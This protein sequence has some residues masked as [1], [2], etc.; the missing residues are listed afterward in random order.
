MSQ[1][2]NHPLKKL[3][4]RS[5]GYRSQ[6]VAL[7]LLTLVVGAFGYLRIARAGGSAPQSDDDKRCRRCENKP[8]P[9][10]TPK[11]TP[12]PAP[13][14]DLAGQTVN[15]YY[16]REAT[17]IAAVLNA[18]ASQEDSELHGLVIST[19][20][21]NEI[22]LYGTKQQ[23]K[24]ARQV[25]ATLDLPRPGI[26]MEM[27]G[28][29]ISSEKP[30]ALSQVMPQVRAEINRTQRAVR[31]SFRKLQQLVREKVP[32]QDLE[33][34]FQWLLEKKLGYRTALQA[35]RELS[36]ADILLRL[37]AA[38]DPSWATR[39]VADGLNTWLRTSRYRDYLNE[40]PKTLVE[41]NQ[42]FERFFSTRG[43]EYQDNQWVDSGVRPQA[44][45]GRMAI[46]EFALHYGCLVHDPATFSPYSL[47]QAAEALNGRLQF[48]V[49]A[50]NLDIQDLFVAPTLLRIGE[51]VR[52]SPKVEYAQ[53][54]KTTIA[55]LSG[56]AAEVTSGSVSAFDVT[57]PLRLSDLLKKADELSKGTEPFVPHPT[58]NVVGA[59]P[60]AQV[61]GLLGAFGEERSVWRELNA[62]VSLHITPNVLRNMTSAELDI[63]L[64]TGDPEA[65]SRQTGVPPLSRVSKHNLKT[66]VYV[67][68]LDF[69][70]LSAFA[71][72]STLGG[73]RGYVPIIGPIWKGMFGEIPV[74]GKL[75]SWS[76]NPKS[77]YHESLVLTNSFI[78]PTVMGLALLYPTELTDP[79]SG[80]PIK[81]KEAKAFEDQYFYVE[82]YRKH[83]H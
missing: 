70:D 37:A 83:L 5:L 38:K 1:S 7:L 81:Y 75:F 33:P 28:V 34:G 15:L 72:Q 46:L 82:D 53:V 16:F 65:G 63:N 19:A 52:K 39:E 42:P 3:A 76:R 73:G 8:S 58:Q 78:T 10:P 26:T 21:D 35:N 54:G 64:E 13:P 25:I 11:P 2:L 57:P 47:Q 40:R 31:D 48:A 55:S 80:V 44:L 30:E 67:D 68:A 41:V 12:K 22:I 32:D 71:S 18:V 49:D 14:E 60:L 77:V 27:W 56:T 66:R 59:M 61:I 23:R 51:I 9:T 45:Q 79:F 6:L 24:H 17:K 74:A 62:G 29:Q 50:I 69:F 36:V 20:A 43:L 4:T